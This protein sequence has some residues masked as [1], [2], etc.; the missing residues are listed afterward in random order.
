MNIVDT[1]IGER[2][3]T[4]LE[5]LDEIAVG[6]INQHDK[7]K[8]STKVADFTTADDMPPETL[9]KLASIQMQLTLLKGLV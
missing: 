6:L 7:K 5:E 8:T 2:V 3:S 4:L 9:R 1:I